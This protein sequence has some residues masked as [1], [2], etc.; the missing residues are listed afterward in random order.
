LV[1]GLENVVDFLSDGVVLWRFYAPSTLDESLERTLN[2]REERASLAVSLIMIVLGFAIMLASFIDLLNGD[3]TLEQKAALFTVSFLSMFT[4]GPLTVLKFRYGRL[5]KS[6]SM[7]KD[8][9]VTLIGFALAFTLFICTLIEVA[10]EGFWWWL[11]PV[12]AFIAGG[13]ATFLGLQA[14]Q[15]ALSMGIPVFNKEWWSSGEDGTTASPSSPGMEMSPTNRN[16]TNR[17]IPVEPLD[18]D[19]K[20]LV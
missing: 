11:D 17:E 20:D 1:Y 5:L 16:G 15:Q 2:H 10:H 19:G 7:R 13:I 4:L 14:L 12:A 8:G 9:I 18:D 6:T 3:D